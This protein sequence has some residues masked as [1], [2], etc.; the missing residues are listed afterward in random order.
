M[1][2]ISIL[3]MP[4]FQNPA[5]CGRQGGATFDDLCHNYAQERLQLLF[6]DAVFTSQ[7]DLY[8]QVIK[9]LT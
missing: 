8:A 6:H 9:T 3:D 4:G 2:S 1:A 7:Q 5:S